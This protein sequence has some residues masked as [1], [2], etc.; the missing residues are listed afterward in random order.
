MSMLCALTVALMGCPGLQGPQGE[1]GPPG[2]GA[3]AT[4]PGLNVTINNVVIPADLLPEI[5]FTATDDFGTM[6]GLD[7]F[8]GDRDVRFTMAYL[9]GSGT[10]KTA[11]MGQYVSYVTDDTNGQATYDHHLGAGLSENEDGTI[12]Y[13]FETA[14]PDDY[15]ATA[16]HQVGG[17]FTRTHPDGDATYNT[18]AVYTWVPAGGAVTFTR[19]ISTTETCNACHTKLTLH[20]R[21]TEFQYCITCHTP[22]SVDPDTGNTVDMPYMIHQI[23][24]GSDLPSGEAYRIIGYRN[25][26]HDY[27]GVEMPQSP[28]NCTVCHTEAV[29]G[30][31]NPVA[32]N[33]DAWKT[34][35]TPAGCLSCHGTTDPVTGTN[36]LQT[37]ADCTVCHTPEGITDAHRETAAGR[38]VFAMTADQVS[39][40][41]TGLVTIDFS[42]SDS[43][44]GEA[45]TN[46]DTLNGLAG[47][48]IAWP[49]P[50]FN[51]DISQFFPFGGTLTNNGEGNYR[52]TLPA[53]M[54]IPVGTSDT[55]AIGFQGRTEID[56]DG[57]PDS[58]DEFERGMAPFTPVT[59]RTDGGES[60][61]RRTVVEEA[62]CLACH[63]EIRV[64]GTLRAG[65]ALCLMCHH[66]NQ[67]DIPF[68]D[69]SDEAHMPED[70]LTVNFKDM[71]HRIHRGEELENPYT[72]VGF[73][74]GLHE[75]NEVLFPGRL[76]KCSIC[77]ADNDVSLPLAAEALAT[78]VDNGTTVTEVL[79][80]TAA[81][82]SCHDGLMA[83]I[84][85][86]LN[87]M[88][89]VETCVICHGP[90]AVADV[91][92]VH[93]L[94]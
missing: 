81:C 4:G 74:G 5:T 56:P 87:T 23:H 28:T 83:G 61:E 57:V 71:I 29:D 55:F 65:V 31:G 40:D 10:A 42:V 32:P 59:F 16:T 54:E 36:H 62:S 77:H 52:Y 51:N 78:S 15:D 8:A 47:I 27:A 88:D 20:G 37:P 90:G 79:P 7:Q 72:V 44:S 70:A 33:A 49:V 9:E 13:K 89:G 94:D 84:H 21:R 24:M 80:T 92:A 1:Q 45:V 17:Q 2:P 86:F 85:A 48:V 76:E 64:H 41:E 39:V 19:E 58:G 22:Q 12:T 93:T 50:E 63:D 53:G 91:E 46:L 14:L 25:S 35:P 18:N 68:R 73:G 34:N 66:V 30:D 69:G 67:T 38:L 43:E 26:V 75:F 6:V 82:T 3:V 11:P 60:A